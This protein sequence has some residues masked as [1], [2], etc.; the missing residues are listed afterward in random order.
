MKREKVVLAYSGGLDTS[1][2]VKWI[3]E[4][5]DLDVVC[6]T[7]E[8]GQGEDLEPIKKKALETGA[9]EA[10]AIDARRIFVD[11]FVWPSL[12]AGSLYEGR[13]PLA[14]ALGRPLIAKLMIDV[15]REAGAVAVAHGCTGKGNDQVRFDVAFQML[16]PELRIIAPVREWRMSR[17][18]EIEYAAKHGIPVETSGAKAYSIDQNT[19]IR[20]YA[21]IAP[22]IL[23]QVITS[24]RR[25]STTMIDATKPKNATTTMKRSSSRNCLSPRSATTWDAPARLPRRIAIL[26]VL[27]CSRTDR[28]PSKRTPKETTRNAAYR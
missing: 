22:W 18:E 4:R 24:E 25:T 13:Y 14:T 1:V 19:P 11:Y 9:V 8:L 10:R 21:E 3:Q 26:L 20:R 7:V 23:S 12:L 5:Y 28:T 16:A 17:P 6:L 15:A 27:R 2:A